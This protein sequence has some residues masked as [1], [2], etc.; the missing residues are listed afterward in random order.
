MH[1]VVRGEQFEALLMK[2]P[3]T[4]EIREFFKAFSFCR[5]GIVSPFSDSDF[6]VCFCD[7]LAI[8]YTTYMR[9]QYFVFILIE[10]LNIF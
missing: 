9:V 1:Q 3:N 5:S 7:P 2:L 6:T 8:Q 10:K 4:F